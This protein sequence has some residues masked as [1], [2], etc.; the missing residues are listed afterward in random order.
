MLREVYI[1]LWD[2]EEAFVFTSEE[3]AID[4][5]E[6]ITGRV[7]SVW[8]FDNGDYDDNGNSVWYNEATMEDGL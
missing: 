2:R 3:K 6:Q 5:V 7:R 8:A 4:K 1:V